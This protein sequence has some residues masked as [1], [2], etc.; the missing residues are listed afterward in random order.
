[1]ARQLFPM[2]EAGT[3]LSGP[4]A[5][6]LL[7]DV[8]MD[9]ERGVPLWSGGQPVLVTGAEAVKSWAWR[10]LQTARYRFSCLSWDYGCELES[11]AGQPYGSETRRSEA[12]RYVRQ[13]LEVCPYIRSVSA[14]VDGL[15][16]AVL[17]IHAQI[18][19]VYGE[20]IIDV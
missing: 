6:P 3:A 15:E 1:M 9:Y 18:T 13:A 11:L 16:G 8:A 10:A 19:T 5:L 17:H 7:R 2:F 4:G 12:V 20:A 14:S